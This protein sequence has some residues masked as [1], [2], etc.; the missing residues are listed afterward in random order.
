MCIIGIKDHGTPLISED[1]LRQCW[2]NNGDGAG[3]AYWNDTTAEWEVEKGF[4]TFDAFL[5]AF[6]AH[7][8]EDKDYYIVHFRF[9]T[10]GNK[11]SGNTHPF[12][13]FVPME[14]MRNTK[15]SSP[16]ITVMNGSC[17][18]GRGIYSDTMRVIND[19]IN[20]LYQVLVDHPEYEDLLDP[21]LFEHMGTGKNR[22]LLTNRG[23]V[24]TYGAGWGNDPTGVMWSNDM[25]KLGN[26]TP[27]HP[28]YVKPVTTNYT[29]YCGRLTHGAI[30]WVNNKYLKYDGVDSVWLDEN[31][32][33]AVHDKKNY[34]SDVKL[35]PDNTKYGTTIIPSKIPLDLIPDCVDARVNMDSV[36]TFDKPEH[37]EL[38]NII[39]PS[40]LTDENLNRSPFTEFKKS[41]ILCSKC[42]TVFNKDTG[43][44]LLFTDPENE[45][46]VG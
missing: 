34:K 2:N 38:F 45:R 43:E 3:F 7:K 9:G 16:Y 24:L 41:G 40:C 28:D 46:K 13:L 23:V 39:C 36:F 32:W 37:N 31:T 12:Q 21:I 10:I 18:A 11:D 14:E 30:K 20:P 19:Y 42:N 8:F 1:T 25:Y 44:V 5:T 33:N 27:R 17:G 15:F 29:G 26:V 6:N 4:M 22:W 35:L